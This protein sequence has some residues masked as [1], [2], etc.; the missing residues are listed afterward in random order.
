MTKILLSTGG[1]GGHI[2]PILSLYAK[3]RK[4]EEIKDIKIITD[5]RAKKFIKVENI[6]IIKQIDKTFFFP[7]KSDKGPRIIC[8]DAEVNK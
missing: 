1:T 5:E 8:K 4:I 7:K 3:L 2:F 6:K